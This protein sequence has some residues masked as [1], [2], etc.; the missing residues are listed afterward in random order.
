MNRKLLLLIML[1]GICLLSALTLDEAKEMALKNNSK[2]LAVKNTYEA[3]RWNRQQSLSNML[4]SLTASGT[5]LYLDPATTIQTGMGTTTL[6]HDSRSAALTLTQPLFMGGKLWQAYKIS[7]ISAEMSRLSLENMRLT[8]LSEVES[9][10]Y[11]VLQLQELLT[12]AQ[13]DLQS[14]RQSLNIIASRYESGVL[15]QADYY[16]T[17]SRVASKEVALIQAQTAMELAFQDLDNT[18]GLSQR[19]ALEPVAKADADEQLLTLAEFT[20]SQT[21]SF[22]RKAVN[23]SQSHNLSL[24]TA[25]ASVNLSQKAYNIARGSFLPTVALSLSRSF[26]DI[27]NERYDFDASNT[28]ALT[29]SVPLLPLWN[30]YSA[31]RKAYYDVL[32]SK[33]DYKTANDGIGLSVQAS[34]L[35]LISNAR[36]VKAAKI[37]LQYTELTYQQIVERFKSNMLSVTEMLDAEIMLQAAQVSYANA[38]YNYLKAKSAL[39]QTLGTDDTKTIE[40]LID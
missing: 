4:P 24:K 37:A 3:A 34:A 26:K 38:F 12:I 21:E 1:S 17:Q 13:K 40:A 31:S 23:M 30:N 10:Y 39:L 5:Y 25:S 36:Q 27:G 15:S 9:K 28:L 35:S 7:S 32:K 11:G 22:T 2:Y 14:S 20:T 19:S 16:K 29:A 18:L 8:V 33:Q 6:N